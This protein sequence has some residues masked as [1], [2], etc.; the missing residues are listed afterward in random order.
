MIWPSQSGIIF[1]DRP[2]L[3]LH[4]ELLEAK[5]R[6]AELGQVFVGRDYSLVD[7]HES[8]SAGRVTTATAEDAPP[9]PQPIRPENVGDLQSISLRRHGSPALA[10]RSRESPSIPAKPMSGSSASGSTQPGSMAPPAAI[11]GPRNQ[12]ERPLAQYRSPFVRPATRDTINGQV[13]MPRAAM[14]RP[15]AQQHT[16]QTSGWMLQSPVAQS[17][18]DHQGTPLLRG[19]WQSDTDMRH[20]MEIARTPHHQTG[21]YS[22]IDQQHPGLRY[23]TDPGNRPRT[24]QHVTSGPLPTRP[25]AAFMPPMKRKAMQELDPNSDRQTSPYY[26]PSTQSQTPTFHKRFAQHTNDVENTTPSRPPLAGAQQRLA[27]AI[28]TPQPAATFGPT[29]STHRSRIIQHENGQFAK[30]HAVP[31]TPISRPHTDTSYSWSGPVSETVYKPR[32]ITSPRMRRPAPDGVP[33]GLMSTQPGPV[34]LVTPRRAQ[35]PGPGP[36]LWSIRGAK[37]GSSIGR[38]LPGLDALHQRYDRGGPWTGRR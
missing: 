22:L 25:N 6:L 13:L 7:D 34:D 32:Q 2:V 35:G 36:G 30:R 18:A 23:P 11:P 38:S 9:A 14:T 3:T 24:E 12:H 4:R 17:T 31:V 16:P 19:R 10:I 29:S 28:Q 1:E 15:S 27:S 5:Q 8:N 37:T 26:Q 21:P 20:T 33:R